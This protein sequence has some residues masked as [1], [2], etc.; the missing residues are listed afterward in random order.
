MEGLIP[1]APIVLS[2]FSLAFTIWRTSPERHKTNSESSKIE[3][4]TITQSQ[5]G[6]NMLFDSYN[7]LLGMRLQS[8]QEMVK[9]RQSVYS[10]E[11]KIKRIEDELTEFSRKFKEQSLRLE[12]E[13]ALRSALESDLNRERRLR[14]EAERTL[15]DYID[16]HQEANDDV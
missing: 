3:A 7:K 5:A 8:D 14:I 6:H 11:V 15:R 12:T 2:F 1:W 4:D 13:I 16:Q 10:Y 9:L